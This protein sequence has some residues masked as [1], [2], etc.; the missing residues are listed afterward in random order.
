[1]VIT[2]T[3]KSGSGK[4]MIG[5]YLAEL[6]PKFIYLDID[7][8][9]HTVLKE[10]TIKKKVFIS[11]PQ[12]I[13]KENEINRNILG[14]IV[15]CNEDEMKK[16]ASITWPRMEEIIDKI[17]KENREK[18]IILDWALIPKTKYFKDSN[19]NILVEAPYKVRLHRAKQRD[20]IDE[21]KFIERENASL[22]YDCFSFDFY[23]NNSNI[24]NT[25]GMV[26]KIYEK[27]SISRKF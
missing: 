8:I 2:I 24:E 14:K 3:G 11:F 5:K 27:S 1:M 17:I 4:S 19:I 18:I 15:F 25:K 26:K 22:N 20:N 9:G 23:L 6:N 13:T 7:K 10:E 16:Y 21:E 12:V